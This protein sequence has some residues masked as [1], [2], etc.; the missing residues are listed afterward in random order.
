MPSPLHRFLF[1]VLA[2]WAVGTIGALFYAQQQ[3]IPSKI[4]AAILPALLLEVAMYL[5]TGFAGVRAWLADL[6]RALPAVLVASALIP[7]AMASGALGNFRADHFALLIALTSAFVLW[8][9]VLPPGLARDLLFLAFGAAVVLSKVFGDV[10]VNPEAKPK[11]DILGRMMWVRLGI[12]SVLLVRGAPGVDYGFIPRVRE[13]VVGARYYLYALVLITPL[14]FGLGFVQ[15]P[16]AAFTSK[17]MLTA[18]L[19]FA[20]MLWFVALFEELFFRGLLQQWLSH[21]TGNA[22]AG[23]LLTSVL[24]GSAHLGFGAFPNW[25]FAIIATC[26]GVIYGLAYTR[27][28]LRGSM[29]TH[30]L[31]ATTWRVVFG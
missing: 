22:T 15:R 14:A 23:L 17:T 26:A 21:S 1:T 8:H 5:A 4:V 7:Y 24:F 16:T 2:V 12:L 29:V 3:N 31:L 28:G 20:G 19:T 9:R 11:L 30:A 25:K 27:A 6:G 18:A 13:W 10:Y